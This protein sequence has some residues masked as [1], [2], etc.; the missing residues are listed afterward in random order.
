MCKGG[1]SLSERLKR[2][3]QDGSAGVTKLVAYLMA[4][5]PDQETSLRRLKGLADMGVNVL[6]VGIPFSDP[7]ADGPVIQSAGERALGA[8]VRVETVLDIIRRFRRE[9][10]IPLLI[11]SYL[12]PLLHY[13]WEAF[14]EDAAAAGVD[15]LILPDLPWGQGRS[16]R[17]KASERVGSRLAFI[18]ILAQTSEKED[19]LLLQAEAERFEQDGS[20]VYILAKN[21]I[22]GGESEI[23]ESV[24]KFVSGI[25]DY[26]LM[27]RC[28]GFGIQTEEQRRRLAGIAEGII[29]G[30]ALVE[31]FAA[32]DK[33]GLE[34]DRVLAAEQEVYSWLD[35]LKA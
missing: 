26:L 13:G 24:R 28:V 8:G 31:R 2:V 12:N 35:K 9:K 18:P 16:L 6:E 4:G 1:I 20:F 21:G 25:R 17:E 19:V 33:A 32:I 22:T 23:H 3:F 10:D 14:V 29:I 15:G 11:M 34:P 7:M 5:D 27:P 30:S